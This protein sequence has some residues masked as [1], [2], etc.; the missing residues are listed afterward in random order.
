MRFKAFIVSALAAAALVVPAGAAHA[1]RGMEVALQDDSVFLTNSWY[2]R[3]LGFQRAKELGVT[4]LRVNVLWS[5]VVANPGSRSVPANP[6]YNWSNYDSL[7]SQAAANGIKVQLT[8]TGPA[9]AWAEGKHRVGVYKPNARRFASFARDVAS[10]FKGR[11]DRY[12]IW[13]E[14]NWKSWLEPHNSSPGIYR[15]LYRGAYSA[16]KRADRRAKVLIGETSPQARGRAGMAPLTW[17]RKMVGRSHLKA[18]GYAH[19][20]Y[21]YRHSPRKVVGGKNDV[22]IASLSRLTKELSRMAHKRLLRTPHGG[23]LPLYLT[24]YG[25][26]VHGRFAMNSRKAAKYL[27]QAFSIAL[28]NP[29]VKSMLQYGLVSPPQVVNW[30]SSLLANNGQARPMFTSLK[31]WVAHARRSLAR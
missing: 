1:A 18:D 20:P 28:H 30:D 15:S 9:P 17:L 4:R 10:H 2:G 19:H 31:S 5:R 11:V 3:D 29:R 25:Y 24:E 16:I 13:N 27:T 14:P 7:I 12:G 21:D 26:L 22:T 6:G 23:A 8:L